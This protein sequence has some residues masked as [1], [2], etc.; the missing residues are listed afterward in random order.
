MVV[1]SA[2][3]RAAVT[4]DLMDELSSERG[5]AVPLKAECRLMVDALDDFFNANQAAINTAIPLT[6]RNTF[7]TSDKARAGAKVLMRRYV[8]GS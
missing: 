4:A 5:H 8:D 1:L 6:A 3:A 7:S 2:A